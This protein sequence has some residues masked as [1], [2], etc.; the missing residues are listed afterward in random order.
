[1]AVQNPALS[2]GFQI[3]AIGQHDILQMG[4]GSV[5]PGADMSK[6]AADIRHTHPGGVNLIVLGRSHQTGWKP[7]AQIGS[8]GG[9][10]ALIGLLLPAV[11]KVREAASRAAMIEAL[12]PALSPGGQIFIMG[13]QGNLVPAV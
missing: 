1:M 2:N 3:T 9:Y 13:V 8:K 10:A 5:R 4:D 6:I 7:M 12:K 11:Q